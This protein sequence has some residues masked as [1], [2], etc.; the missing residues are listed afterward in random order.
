M[1]SAGAM[2]SRH[3]RPADV[4]A[5]RF[6]ARPMVTERSR[7]RLDRGGEVTEESGSGQGPKEAKTP[8]ARGSRPW[9][10][11]ASRDGAEWRT[12]KVTRSPARSRA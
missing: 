6:E 1:R 5:G 2:Q 7:K 12:T 11:T 4:G 9:L 8:Y 3:D 10:R